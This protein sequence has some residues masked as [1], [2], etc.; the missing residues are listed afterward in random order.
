MILQKATSME[1]KAKAEQEIIKL[2]ACVKSIEDMIAVDEAVQDLL[3][4]NS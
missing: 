2:S 3:M 4:K 1:E